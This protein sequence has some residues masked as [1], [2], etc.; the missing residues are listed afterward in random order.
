MRVGVQRDPTVVLVF[1]IEGHRYGVDTTAVQ[2][3]VR[4]VQTVRLPRAPAVITGVVNLRGEVLPVLD[5][6]LRFGLPARSL[7]ADDV[8]LI[9][10]TATRLLALRADRVN[11]LVRVPADS[12]T[13]IGATTPRSQYALGTARLDD[14]LLVICDLDGFLDEAE[15]LSLEGAL[16]AQAESAAP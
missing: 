14:G 7:R 11:E 3:I 6:R 4:A 2:E 1:E 9:V 15:R 10:R 5:M 12:L 16:R 13:A 8:F